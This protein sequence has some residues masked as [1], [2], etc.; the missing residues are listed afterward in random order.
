MLRADIAARVGTV[1]L[2]IGFSVAAGECLALVGPSGAGKTSVLRAGAGLLRPQRGT[3]TCGDAVW[4]GPG[5]DLPPDRR[6]VG[7]VFQD[8]A[9]FPHLSAWRNVAYP[10]PRGPHRRERAHALLDRLGVAHRADARPRELSG[11]E[12]QRVA[13]ARALARDPEVLLL[14]EP[15]S[16]LDADNRATAARELATAIADAGLPTVFVTHDFTEAA[17]LGQRVAVL[18]DG[19]VVQEGTPADL[20]AAPASSFVAGFTGAN[21]LTGSAVDDPDGLAL[22]TLDGGGTLLSTDAARGR[23]AVVVFP[24]ELALALG[25][26]PGSARNRLR[27]QVVSLTTV[28]NR[29]RV[30]LLAGQPL[31]AEITE[32]AA[33]ALELTPGVEVDVVWKAAATRLVAL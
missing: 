7:M 29:V 32:P 19:R 6:R 14:D 15:L 10:M 16:G 2:E 13:L 30:G 33:R 3:V 8:H 28:A 22:V 5:V 20:A 21:V 23:V 24:W 1:D 9:L 27:A 31:A 12:R 17:L 18:Q 11:G 25:D 4:F 26:S